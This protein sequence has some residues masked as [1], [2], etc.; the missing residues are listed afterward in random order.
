MNNEIHACICLPVINDETKCSGCQLNAK[1]KRIEE[2]EL[3]LEMEKVQIIDIDKNSCAVLTTEACIK[4][5][6]I[7]K[8]IQDKF[9]D[10]TGVGDCVLLSHGIELKHIL[11]NKDKPLKQCCICKDLFN[12]DSIIIATVT[13]KFYCTGCWVGTP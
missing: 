7:R 3:L 10:L 4:D 12:D 6:D 9:M 1:N 8:Q 11:I 2:L 5:P 13:D